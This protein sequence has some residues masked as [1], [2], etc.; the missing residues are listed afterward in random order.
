MENEL[1]RLYTSRRQV[2]EAR[3]AHRAAWALL[4][5]AGALPSAPVALRFELVCTCYFRGTQERPL[6]AADPRRGLVPLRF[7]ASSASVWRRPSLC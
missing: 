3:E 7:P 6:P 4:Q 2:A 5:D 1:G